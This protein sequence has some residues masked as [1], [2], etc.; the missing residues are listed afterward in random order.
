MCN[1]FAIT[2]TTM[3]NSSMLCSRWLSEQLLIDRDQLRKTTL[4]ATASTATSNVSSN[5]AYSTMHSQHAVKALTA[6]DG[7]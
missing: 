5:C 3:R 1:H 2:V 4:A 6:P 7:A